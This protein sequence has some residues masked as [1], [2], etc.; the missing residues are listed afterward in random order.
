MKPPLQKGGAKLVDRV[1][2]IKPTDETDQIED[3]NM[4]SS[5]TSYLE[6]TARASRDSAHSGYGGPHTRVFRPPTPWE[7]ANTIGDAERNARMSKPENGPRKQPLDCQVCPARAS[8]GLCADLTPELVS[9]VASHKSGDREFKAGEDL[10]SLGEPCDSIYNLAHGWVI[11]YNIL[12]DGRRQILHFALPGAVLGFHPARGATMTYGA[13]ALT[14]IVVCTI[15]HK[16]LLPLVNQQ[17]EL[18]LRL[19]W[20]IARDCSLAFDRLTSIG[21]HSARE[22]VAHLLLK[23]FIRYRAQWP[24]SRIEEMHLPLTQEHIGDATGLTFV[25]V[26]RV[27]RNLRK[28]GILEFHYRRLRILDPD[29]LVDVA[30]IDPQL[31][32]SWI[33]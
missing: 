23:L 13:Q 31:V 8:R 20:L 18:G 19:A 6:S 14:D 22:R 26:N 15:P 12:E 7:A 24:G 32:I 4:I 21:R 27:L 10:F 9:V 29:K 25:H 11:L 16:A 28:D 17:P 1:R 30:G 5:Q 33:N 2:R 3:C